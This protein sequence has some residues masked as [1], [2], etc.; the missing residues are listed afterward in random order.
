MEKLRIVQWTTGKVG[1][2]ALRAILDDPRMELVGVYAHSPEKAGRDAA[3]H[4]GR[5]A[6][7]IGL[8][9]D[10]DALI[11]QRP[12]AVVYTPFHA[13]MDHVTRLLRAGVNVVS[14]NLFLN[15]GGLDGDVRDRLEDACE[16]GG[17]SLYITGVNPGWINNIAAALSLVCRRVDRVVI[18]ESANVSNYASKETWE[19]KGFG[20]HGIDDAMRESARATMVSFRDAATSLAEALGLCLDSVEFEAE[21]ATARNDLDLGYMFIA[22]GSNAALRSSWVGR[23]NGAEMVRISLTW[24]LTDQLNEDWEFADDHYFVRIDGEPGIDTRIRFD[25]PK[26]SGSDWSILTALPA[27]G[28]VPGV[29]AARPGVLSLGEVGLLAAPVGEWLRRRTP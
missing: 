2:Q 29:V 4:C 11:A 22:E 27:V 8:T 15:E 18:S 1:M 26:W 24:Y 16:A 19:S 25:A 10:I 9:S 17:A 12:D 20:R 5:E 14:T 23:C 3:V 21:F 28:A 6:C 13:D 7:G